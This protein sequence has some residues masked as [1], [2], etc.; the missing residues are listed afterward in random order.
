MS[1]KVEDNIISLSG[2]LIIF[3]CGHKFV[4][5]NRTIPT[6]NVDIQENLQCPTCL[7]RKCL[8]CGGVFS[9]YL[10]ACPSCEAF[11]L[12]ECWAED[13]IDQGFKRMRF[14]Q[15]IVMVPKFG[16]EDTQIIDWTDCLTLGIGDIH[17]QEDRDENNRRVASEDL[18][19]YLSEI[20]EFG[21]DGQVKI[22]YPTEPQEVEIRIENCD[23]IPDCEKEYRFIAVV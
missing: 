10:Y 9:G 6:L 18:K 11:G 3:G 22:M 8:A 20:H 2:T 7:G 13:A 19:I 12:F 15:G 23:T 17:L 5:D 21:G 1:R 14:E 4:Q 16:K